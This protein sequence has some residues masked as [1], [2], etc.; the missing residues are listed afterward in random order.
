MSATPIVS[1]TSTPVSTIDCTIG[2]DPDNGVGAYCQ[3]DGYT[4]KLSTLASTTSPYK[5]CGYTT[6]PAEPSTTA[7]PTPK[8]AY[9]FTY[10]DP[11]SNII[12]CETSPVLNVAGY[13][14]GACEGSTS[15]VYTA[16]TPTPTATY[17]W[18]LFLVDAARLTCA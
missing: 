17:Q 12:I 7:T 13:Q 2:Q 15:T 14:V 16:P 1:P 8:E 18:S 9:Q 11:S 10:T 6:L 5:P 4:G 3:C